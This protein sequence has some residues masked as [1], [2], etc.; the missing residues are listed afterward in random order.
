MRGGVLPSPLTMTLEEER[1]ISLL[2][3][4]LSTVRE[5]LNALNGSLI[6]Q[7]INGG[8]YSSRFKHPTIRDAFAIVIADDREL[9][10]IYLVGAPVDRLI[11][12]V[13]C[14]DVGIHGVKV[15]V[16]SYQYD[17]IINRLAML[18]T[19]NWEMRRHLHSFIAYRCARDF[20]V[21]Y[22]ARNPSF[23]SNLRVG[24]YL[25]AVSDLDVIV[26]LHE[27]GLLPESKR[28]SVVASIREFA[29][30]TPDSGFLNDGIQNL[31]T[32]EEFATILE[33]IRT[34]LLPDLGDTIQNWCDNLDD[35][36][37]ENYFDDLVSALNEFRDALAEDPHATAQIDS[38]LIKFDE[39]I[40]ELRSNQPQDASF[41]DFRGQTT[42]ER[43]PN[44]FRSIFD[45][46]DE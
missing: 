39:I 35:N 18:D 19:T 46:V 16:P 11:K 33:D 38:A 23:V 26:R 22:I 34:E 4:S 42:G 3:G 1:A 13:T 45:D 25:Y 30:L 5:A 15:T 41:E 8:D 44:D 28:T 17:L 43:R 32:E 24:S 36:D 29:V 37:P 10:D 2:G 31:L 14:G 27:F 6:L 20:L 7:I 9:L 21:D 40:D 12:E